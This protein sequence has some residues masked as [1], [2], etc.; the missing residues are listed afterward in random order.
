MVGYSPWGRK[1]SDTTELLHLKWNLKYDTD[2]VICKIEADSQA[3]RTKLSLPWGREHGEG[4]DWEF[5]VSR[6][7]LLY[8][9]WISNKV[10]LYRELCSVSRDKP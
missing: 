2:E 6:C 7:R 9:E 10:L 3:E 5:G 4:M 1:E 8:I